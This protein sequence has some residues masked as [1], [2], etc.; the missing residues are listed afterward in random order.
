MPLLTM[1]Q[2]I[3]FKLMVRMRQCRD[4]ML[5][6][7]NIL[8]PNIK[9]KLDYLVTESRKWT[10]GWDGEKKFLVKCG[11]RAVTV[12]LE[13]RTCD[14]RYFD[15]TGIPCAHA[16]AAIHDRRHRPVD[17]I[18]DYYKRDKYLAAYSH[19]LEAI[20]GEE[21][22]EIHST[23][24][25]LPPDIPKKLRGRPKRLR[26]KEQ[27]EGGNRSQ[28]MPNI[29]DGPVIQRFSNKRTMH[30]S[31]C[32]DSSHR[33]TNCPTKGD[34]P[35]KTQSQ[36]TNRNTSAQPVKKTPK[37]SRRQKL[38]IKRKIVE[39]LNEGSAE[40]IINHDA[41][42]TTTAEAAKNLTSEEGARKVT[43]KGKEHAV[44][45]YMSDEVF[46]PRKRLPLTP[47]SDPRGKKMCLSAEKSKQLEEALLGPVGYHA[48]FMPTPG[49]TK[50]LPT[51]AT[52]PAT[53]I[54]ASKATLEPV[55]EL[56]KRKSTRL[57]NTKQFKFKN[58]KGNPIN[59]AED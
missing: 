15:L 45:R 12:N 11:T 55:R 52:P 17:Y 19:S 46:V 8:C 31:L 34:V 47:D 57:N 43:D 4:D 58:D 5:K 6:T 50:Y 16:I 38:Q 2:E 14:C 56:A 24:E 37:E 39:D 49:H 41:D 53:D 59:L 36:A 21:Y 32:G 40:P 22:W 23:D 42:K 54:P 44:A 48:V 25:L 3:H 35:V 51:G 29:V 30:C 27:W 33:K 26:R 7:D 20:K 9:K 13:S 18:S 28:A 10:A 1:M